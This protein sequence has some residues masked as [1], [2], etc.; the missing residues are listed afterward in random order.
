MKQRLLGLLFRIRHEGVFRTI[1]FLV[2]A[3]RPGKQ[4]VLEL[5]GPP[6]LHRWPCAEMRIVAGGDYVG[7]MQERSLPEAFYR[8]E[9]SKGRRCFVALLH[10]QPTGILWVSDFLHPSHLVT[11]ERGEAE[12]GNAYVVERFRGQGVFQQLIHKASTTLLEE[13]CSRIYAV[14]DERNISSRRALARTGFTHAADLSRPRTVLLGAKFRG[15]KVGQ[16]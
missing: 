9:L 12:L 11:L 15:T 5:V 13:G 3:C 14:V 10:G 6:I 1:H 2:D 16:G 4:E 8:G 7:E